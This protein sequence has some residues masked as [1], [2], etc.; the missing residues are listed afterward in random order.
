MWGVYVYDQ[1]SWG[2]PWVGD[3]KEPGWKALDQQRR[4]ESL[5]VQLPP[6]VDAVRGG[7]G[8]PKGKVYGGAM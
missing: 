8:I 3:G 1:N 4:L 5:P 6:V 2:W 7:G